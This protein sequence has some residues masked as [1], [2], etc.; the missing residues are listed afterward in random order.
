MASEKCDK[1]KSIFT[2]EIK[3]IRKLAEHT[4]SEVHYQ[5]LH[6]VEDLY[7][8]VNRIMQEPDKEPECENGCTIDEL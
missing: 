6:R 4:Q 1:V 7:K 2:D 5:M 8:K 3:D